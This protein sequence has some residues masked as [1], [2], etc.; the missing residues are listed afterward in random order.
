MIQ[1]NGGS[2]AVTVGA[3]SPTVTF[4]HTGGGGGFQ[5]FTNIVSNTRGDAVTAACNGMIWRITNQVLGATNIVLVPDAANSLGG[6]I[7]FFNATSNSVVL[8]NVGD[9]DDDYLYIN[10]VAVKLDDIIG[11][12]GYTLMPTQEL[13]IKAVGDDLWIGR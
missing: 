10:G 1:V 6:V 3:D 9:G 4:G 5:T 13:I 2:S 11:G 7:D 8:Y 12:A